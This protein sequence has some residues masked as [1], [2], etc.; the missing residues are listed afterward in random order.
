MVVRLATIAM[1]VSGCGVVSGC[2]GDV[3]PS[4]DAS[5]DA[6]DPADA[7]GGVLFPP[8]DASGRDVTQPDAM[9]PDANYS[10]TC[11]DVGRFIGLATCCA[12]K[13]CS[14]SCYQGQYCS[15]DNVQGGCPW[16]LVCCAK[17][18]GCVSADICQQWTR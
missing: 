18:P 1:L 3:T 8:F 15:C 4:G 11:S 9:K 14:G 16:P 2:G 6:S 17:P 12:N 13:Y 7:D 10:P 5:L